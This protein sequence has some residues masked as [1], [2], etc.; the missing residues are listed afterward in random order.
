M[1]GRNTRARS[2]FIFTRTKT[3]QPDRRSLAYLHE[4]Q[5]SL[6]CSW[7]AGRVRLSDVNRLCGDHEECP[8]T[9]D[10]PTPADVT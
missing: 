8:K 2:L 5:L 10:P 9:G 3:K 4:H 7:L 6:L 1:P